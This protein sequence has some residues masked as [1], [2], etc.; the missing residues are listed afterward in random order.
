MPHVGWLE[1]IRVLRNCH[2]EVTVILPGEK[3]Q[4]M[5]GDDVRAMVAP[6][7]GVIHQALDAKVGE[8]RGTTAA[9]QVKQVR[10]L[11][12]IYFHFHEGAIDDEEFNALIEDLLYVHKPVGVH[13]L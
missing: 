10:H 2:P 1:A 7:V 5:P 13:L 4:V 11:L 3:I 12:N 6:Y 8:W 9:S